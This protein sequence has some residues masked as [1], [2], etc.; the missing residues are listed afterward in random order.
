MS[1]VG[2]PLEHVLRWCVCKYQSSYCGVLY[3]DVTIDRQAPS[4]PELIGSRCPDGAI[5]LHLA[6]GKTFH[7]KRGAQQTS[8]GQNECHLHHPPTHL[9]R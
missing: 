7:C 1:L 4:P 6:S 8:K 3:C 9:D 2:I 5:E